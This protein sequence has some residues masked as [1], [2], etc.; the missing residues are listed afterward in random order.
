MIMWPQNSGQVKTFPARAK[1]K[2]E[3]LQKF[4]KLVTYSNWAAVNM[5]GLIKHLIA[6]QFMF[7]PTGAANGKMFK[8][9]NNVIGSKGFKVKEYVAFGYVWWRQRGRQQSILYETNLIS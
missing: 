9:G 1:P 6:F 7:S 4:E 8:S 3:I 5:S 2:Y